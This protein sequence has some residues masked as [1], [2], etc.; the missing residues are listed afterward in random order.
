MLSVAAHVFLLVQDG[1]QT[2]N[3]RLA[4]PLMATLKTALASEHAEPGLVMPGLPGSVV[5]PRPLI[6]IQKPTIVTSS[7]SLAPVVVAETPPQAVDEPRKAVSPLSPPAVVT[8]AGAVVG[9]SAGLNADGLREYRFALIG[10]AGRMKQHYEDQLLEYERGGMVDIRIQVE[11][12]G[13]T[14]ALLNKSSGYAALDDLAL[15]MMRVA[16]ARAAV[17][18]SLHGLSFFVDLPVTFNLKDK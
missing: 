2:P 1:F 13:G 16:A 15:D 11:P 18:G 14:R 4:Q 17:P 9:S 8:N 3:L 10:Q 12:D 7:S 5:R 6:P